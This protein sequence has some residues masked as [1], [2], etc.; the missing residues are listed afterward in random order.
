L[1]FWG[2][3]NVIGL[4]LCNNEFGNIFLTAHGINSDD[5]FFYFKH[6]QKVRILVISFSF[7][8][9]SYSPRTS[10]LSEAEADRIWM[11]AIPK[12]AFRVPLRLFHQ[13]QKL[14]PQFQ[15]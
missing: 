11:E 2:S 12:T 15:D 14:F 5:S 8:S 6:L 7:L 10:L 13:W 3:K 4:I 9:T 1:F